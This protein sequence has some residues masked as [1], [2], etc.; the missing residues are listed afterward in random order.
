M[1]VAEK[2]F[3][4]IFEG[5][6]LGTVH[7]A[8]KNIEH[9]T[10]DYKF[11]VLKRM[12]PLNPE[13]L[14]SKNPNFHRLPN[15]L[16][17]SVKRDGGYHTLYYDMKGTPESVLCNSP[18]GRIIYN[19][20]V[21]KEI[22]KRIKDINTRYL[23]ELRNIL[24]KYNKLQIFA[25]KKRIETIVLAGELFAN[26]KKIND[27]P[28]VF[29]YIKLTRNPESINDLNK[30]H[31]DVFDIISINEVNLLDISYEYRIDLVDWFFPRVFKGKDE[32]K[33]KVV[34]HKT[35]VKSEEVLELYKK[36]VINEYNEGIVIRTKYNMS[37]KVKPRFDIDAVIIGFTEM[38]QEEKINDQ[39]AINSLM[40]AVMRD[41]GTYQEVAHVGGGFSEKQ[42]IDF[43]NLLKDDIVESD[44]KATK[45][46]GRA[47][48]FIIPKYVIQL[49]Y[50]DIITEGA[51]GTTINKV[52][53]RFDD[54]TWKMIQAVPFV[55]IISPQFE[56][57]RSEVDNNLYSSL[58]YANIKS[59]THYDVNINQISS[60]VP[61]ESP[62]TV[63]AQK[64]LPSVTILLKLVF[65]GKWGGVESA[66][67]ILF[68]ETNKHEIDPSYPRYII[69]LTDYSYTRSNPLEQEI[70]PFN[71]LEKAIR[72]I[73]FL[74]KRP[75]NPSEGLL[76]NKQEALKRSLLKPPY[77]L[78][79]NQKIEDLLKVHLD[80]VIKSIIFP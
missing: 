78:E 20:P 35:G 30:I 16:I 57:L 58:E 69:Y 66:K 51:S 37:Y 18:G 60:I 9:L 25:Q 54:N 47:F 77:K 55:S 80:N 2:D 63:E 22:Q 56:L 24:R 68:W 8:N 62:K 71:S 79:I 23:T 11:S 52:A 4:S 38:L 1:G 19:L 74:F 42:R 64:E 21:N 14:D 50:S 67:K 61:I 34:E 29:D 27:R 36:W 32:P 48:H 33:A 46:D 76:D 65:E 44:Y 3:E 10:D 41:D 49:I 40:V 6:W 45:R 15:D 72:H 7:S 26:V 13:Y 43:Y 70:Y 28:R 75:D 17:V 12:I 53:L 59:A 73:N 39:D 31:Y 5:Y